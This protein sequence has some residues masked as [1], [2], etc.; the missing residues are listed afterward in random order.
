[1]PEATARKKFSCPAC[2]AEAQWNP[3]TQALIC[4]FCGTT[5]PAQAELTASGEQVIKEHDLAAA[6]RLAQGL[7]SAFSMADLCYT[8]SVVLG[9]Y[10]RAR[11][12]QPFVY[13]EG[14]RGL[15]A[16]ET[17][18]PEQI[19]LVKAFTL[20]RSSGAI[21][22]IC[23]PSIH[24][25]SKQVRARRATLWIHVTGRGRG[26]IFVRDH[27]LK[28]KDTGSLNMTE[29]TNCPRIT[30]KPYS[31]LSQLWAEYEVKKETE[32]QAYLREAQANL[33]PEGESK[34]D[35]K[36]RLAAERQRAKRARDSTSVLSEE[37]VSE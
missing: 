14:V 34:A 12:G 5:S 11:R 2:G 1:M 23:I 26:R 17:F 15:L 37:P 6:L 3:D 29:W 32:K 31:P 13:D 22:F 36:R 7:N 30:W 16:G 27:R 25:L 8:A 24:M 20:V 19:A 35:R 9:A 21:L 28:F 33:G 18:S 4:A 10:R